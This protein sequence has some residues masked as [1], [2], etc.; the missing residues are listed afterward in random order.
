[1]NDETLLPCPV[2]WCQYNDPVLELTLRYMGEDSPRRVECQC[3]VVGPVKPTDEAAI[4]AWNAR[5]IMDH[6][7]LM[8]VI[9][10]PL[11]LTETKAEQIAASFTQLFTTG[12]C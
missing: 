1:M 11:M 10:D 7:Y 8:M 2:P 3:G 6:D 4:A 12:K 5:P 9:D